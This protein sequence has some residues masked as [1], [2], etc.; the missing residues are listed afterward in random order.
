LAARADEKIRRLSGGMRQRVGLAASVVNEPRLLLLDEPTNGLDLEQRLQFRELV[1]S[2]APDAITIIS[3]HLTEDLAPICDHVIVLREGRV[4]FHGTLR[5][6]CG[7]D[8][9]GATP[10][11]EQLNTA[12]LGLVRP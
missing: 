4:A 9:V 8:E 11:V 3:S 1:R 10:S 12:Y 6:L 2:L 5:G 7:L